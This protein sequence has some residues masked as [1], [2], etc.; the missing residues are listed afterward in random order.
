MSDDF[1]DPPLVFPHSDTEENCGDST[2]DAEPV[3][4][5]KWTP[6]CLQLLMDHRIDPD[7]LENDEELEDEEEEDKLGEFPTCPS[8]QCFPD[9]KFSIENKAQEAL[10]FRLPPPKASSKARGEKLQLESV[11]KRKK[12]TDKNEET[13]EESEEAQQA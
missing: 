12:D 6:E 13:E 2:P 10:K 3:M 1:E 5:D 7:S 11:K 8:C 9:S 4:S